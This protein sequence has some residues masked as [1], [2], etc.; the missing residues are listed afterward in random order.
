MSSLDGL[1]KKKSSNFDVSLKSARRIL[2]DEWKD[3]KYPSII[4]NLSIVL[5]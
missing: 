1:S 5:F 3:L 4:S 2:S